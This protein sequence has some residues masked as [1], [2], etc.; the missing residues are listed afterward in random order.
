MGFR[1]PASGLPKNLAVGDTVTFEIR[2]TG[3]G[4]F[5]ITSISATTPAPAQPMKGE[6]KGDMTG[7]KK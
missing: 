4:M 7:P 6:T 3:A 1:L 5:E 2:E